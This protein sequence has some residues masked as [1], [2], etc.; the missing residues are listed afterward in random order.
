MTRR[1]VR[2]EESDARLAELVGSGAT[3]QQ[4]AELLGVPED[5][6]RSW[7]RRLGLEFRGRSV[8]AATD[9]R[10]RS[11]FEQGFTAAEIAAETGLARSTVFHHLQRMGLK[12]TRSESGRMG[13]ERS[14]MRTHELG[15]TQAA[16]S[17]NR[18]TSLPISAAGRRDEATDAPA[19]RPDGMF[20]PAQVLGDGPLAR[21]YRQERGME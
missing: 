5:T 12:R 6:V 8:D 20:A 1:T 7:A 14:P 17:G 9:A 21:R 3:R 18:W 19:P 15:G 13:K 11:L 2:T 4:A 16:R 10:M